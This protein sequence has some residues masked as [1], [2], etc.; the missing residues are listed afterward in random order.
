M[1][2][3]L[4]AQRDTVIFDCDGVFYSWNVYGGMEGAKNFLADVKAEVTALILPFLTTDDAKTI[5]RRSYEE[6]GDGLKYFVDIAVENGMDG[7]EFR[8]QMHT[9]YH[10]CQ[11]A[12]V[13]KQ[14]P[15]LLSPCQETIQHLSALSDRVQWGVLS[16]GCRDHWIT[17]LFREKAIDGFISPDKIF[18]FR[19][20]DWNEKSVSAKG[21]GKIMD[22]MGVD[23][24]RV[25]FVEDTKKNLRPVKET[26]A[27]VL[28]VH[29][30][31]WEHPQPE[32]NYIDLEVAS[33]LDF[34]RAFRTTH[35]GLNQVLQR[36]P[37]ALGLKL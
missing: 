14:F 20:F 10:V 22:Y 2:Q 28:T 27:D 37:D 34:L 31:D 4:S 19:E 16:Q 36:K 17:P 11:M 23:P 8:E 3:V 1:K 5:G 26:Y 29:L 33:N 15:N 9:L 24:S 21:L 6:T 7:D 13:R 32:D 25:V 12:R 35:L 30:A 18:G